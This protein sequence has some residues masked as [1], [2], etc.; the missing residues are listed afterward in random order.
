MAGTRRF[1]LGAQPDVEQILLEAQH[2]WLHPPEICEL[3]RNH[4]KFRISHQPPNLPSSGSIFL[5]D[6][7]VVRYFRNDGH[8]WRKKKDGK[9]VKE[10]HEKLRVGSVNELQC[11]YAHGED[12]KNFQRR[13][14]WMLQEELSNIVLVHYRDVKETLL[15]QGHG[16]S[17]QLVAKSFGESQEFGSHLQ[18]LGEWQT[19]NFLV[20]RHLKMILLAN[21][22]HIQTWN[23]VLLQSFVS[24]TPIVLIYLTPLSLPVHIHKIK[25]MFRDSFQMQNIH[26]FCNQIQE[27]ISNVEGKSIYS[28]AI[29]QHLLDCSLPE[30]GLRK[31]ESSYGFMSEKVAGADVQFSSAAH[32][33]TVETENRIDGSS[34]PTQPHVD[35]SMPSSSLSEDQL[36]DIIDFTTN[37]ACVGSETEVY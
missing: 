19:V 14:Y 28:G 11:Y 29:K 1:S 25:M 13:S 36:C 34:I 27:T 12:N 3:L 21:V 8:K 5:F 20:D 18:F 30:E 2:R 6:R 32:R 16:I 4:N 10:S 35:T 17:E 15:K 26:I 37:G 24:K 9:K 33:K 7:K 22:S 31:I 23:K